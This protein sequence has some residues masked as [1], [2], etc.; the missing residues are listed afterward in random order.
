MVAATVVRVVPTRAAI[1]G[2]PET[3]DAA[4]HP[5][6][7]EFHAGRR[8]RA[9]V[10]RHGF[11][12]ADFP[13]VLGAAGGPK[14]LIL[15]GLDRVLAPRIR[16]AARE[17]GRPVDLI[18]ASIGAWRFA[19]W[20]HDDPVAALDRLLAS[21]TR[22][23]R[24]EPDPRRAGIPDFDRLFRNYL[25]E[26]LGEDGAGQVLAC[27][28]ARLHM[29]TAFFPESV[30]PDG[31][32]LATAWVRNLAGRRA[33]RAGARRRL[34]CSSAALPPALAAWPDRTRILDA[35]RLVPALMA[36]AA[37]PGMIR[38]VAGL[39]PDEGSGRAIDGGIVDYHFDGPP[40][41][42]GFT[43]YPH[44]YPTLTPGWF[45]KPF[46]SR[47]HSAEDLDDL[48]L[49]TPTPGF[50]ASLPGAKIP[51]RKDPGRLGPRVCR[52]TWTGVGE[53][54]QRLGEALETVLD[55]DRIPELIG[56]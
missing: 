41:G 19:A 9:H 17:A 51:D 13:T 56:A 18:G 52:K 39:D 11:R 50:V 48:L 27:D 28:E 37:V 49:I 20:L 4:V 46:G 15:Q 26:L 55:E 12:L 16:S 34:V 7:L 3:R 36:T 30:L 21:Y 2:S 44:F 5:L 22:P 40:R 6:P 25:D 10:A 45:D 14:W 38:P 35:A 33:F 53:A 23:D 32:R 24:F 8:V 31:L 42:A 47:R 1:A 29:V 43:L 54:S